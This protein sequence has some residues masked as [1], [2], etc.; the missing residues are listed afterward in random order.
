MQMHR[1]LGGTFAAQGR[2]ACRGQTPT[3]PNPDPIPTPPQPQ[4]PIQ[5]PPRPQ[6][7]PLPGIDHPPPAPINPQAQ[8][9]RFHGNG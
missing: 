3:P 6:E 9:R 1:S 8:T 5:E 4:P 2:I 7:P